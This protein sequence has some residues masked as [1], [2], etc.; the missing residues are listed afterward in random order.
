MVSLSSVEASAGLFPP[1]PNRLVAMS[2][3]TRYLPSSVAQPVVPV[4]GVRLA[5]LTEMVRLLLLLFASMPGAWAQD[6]KR[7]GCT[8]Q[9]VKDL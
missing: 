7:G 1:V 3:V 5:V 4:E 2:S 9:P 6:A 8:Q